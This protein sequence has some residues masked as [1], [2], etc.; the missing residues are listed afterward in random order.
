[1]LVTL[2]FMLMVLL[3][4]CE[5]YR[6]YRKGYEEGYDRGRSDAIKEMMERLNDNR[7]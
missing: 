6:W 5:V 1:M 3:A 7:N 2:M 4:A